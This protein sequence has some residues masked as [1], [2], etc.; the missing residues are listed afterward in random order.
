MNGSVAHSLDTQT[1][2]EIQE[3][4]NYWNKVFYEGPPLTDFEV[5]I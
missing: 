5:D 3:K 2:D 4:T 1:Q